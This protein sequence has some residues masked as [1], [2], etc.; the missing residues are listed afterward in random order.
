ME[1]DALIDMLNKDLADEHA[2]IVRYLIHAYQVGESTPFGSM[3][4]STA[5]EEMWHMDWLGDEIGELDAEP[6]MKQGVYPHDPTSNATLLRSYIE[7]EDNLISMYA[8]QAEGVESEDLK[9]ILR[10]LGIESIAHKRRFEQWLEK[11]GP[12]GEEPFTFEEASFTPEMLQTFHQEASSQYKLVLQHLRHAFVFEEEDCEV[13]TELELT[14]M[15]HMKHLSHFAE[16]LAE[17]GSSFDFDFPGVDK[18]QAI[19]WALLADLKLTKEAKKRFEALVDE[20]E[21]S[22]HLGLSIEL[23]NMITRNDFLAAALEEMLES[24]EY[25]EEESQQANAAE[26]FTVGSLMK[27]KKED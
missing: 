3:L 11:L 21:I 5:R 8:Q 7:W 18:S 1:R 4:L 16:E 23:D 14:A 6:L 9:R 2:S 17:S 20:P 27:K 26:Q 13:G 19:K 22:Q 12:E 10:Q 24:T 15:R 25:S